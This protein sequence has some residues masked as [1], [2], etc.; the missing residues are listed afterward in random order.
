ME[1]MLA[2]LPE[3][4][5][6]NSTLGLTMIL[7]QMRLP[8]PAWFSTTLHLLL[9]FGLVQCDH[10]TLLSTSRNADAILHRC[11]WSQQGQCCRA[12]CLQVPWLCLQIFHGITTEAELYHPNR[13]SLKFFRY[14]M[15]SIL[16]TYLNLK[17]FWSFSAEKT[18]LRLPTNPV[19]F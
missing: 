2:W 13:S 5:L 16:L 18:F 4:C 11:K 19:I 15:K 1:D 12:L 10:K 3:S 17:L 14:R 9:S 8:K 7:P 6:F